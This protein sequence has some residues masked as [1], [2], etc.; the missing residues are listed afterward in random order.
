MKEVSRDDNKIYYEVETNLG[1]ITDVELAYSRDNKLITDTSA[2]HYLGK[3]QY[4]V[5]Q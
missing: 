4:T 3:P 2:F 1:K 5:E